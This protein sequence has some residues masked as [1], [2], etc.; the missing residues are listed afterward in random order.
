MRIPLKLLDPDL[1]VPAHT[2]AGDA[3][4]DL[5]TREDATLDPGQWIVLPTGVAIALP[6]GYA[7]LVLARSGLAAKKGLGVLNA[8]GLVDS[9]YRGEIKVILINHGREPVQVDRGERIAQLV[10]TPVVLQEFEVV[11]DLPESERGKGVLGSS[12][13][14]AER[15]GGFPA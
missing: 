8:P 11:A 13:V 14:T 10:V 1:P 6:D 15:K 3:G 4:V 2:H 9:G 5:H 7:A 12:G